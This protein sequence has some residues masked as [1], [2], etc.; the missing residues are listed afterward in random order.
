MNM[1]YLLITIIIVVKYHEHKISIGFDVPTSHVYRLAMMLS[2]D[3]YKKELSCASNDTTFISYINC[4][5]QLKSGL[6]EAIQLLW[7]WPDQF[8]QAKIGG[9]DPATLVLARPVF[10]S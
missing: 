7:F 3:L 4:I 10:S 1:Y 8:S 5:K 2:V 9:S 6:V